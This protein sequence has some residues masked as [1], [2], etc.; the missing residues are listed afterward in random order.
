MS[1]WEFVDVYFLF[2]CR[3]VTINLIAI[4][5]QSSGELCG[6][7]ASCVRCNKVLVTIQMNL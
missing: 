6:P 7:W 4:L 5:S 2:I 3:N 1:D